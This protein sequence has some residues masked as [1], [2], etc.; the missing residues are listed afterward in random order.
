MRLVDFFCSFSDSVR[1]KSG[2]FII[3]IIVSEKRSYG[4][5]QWRCKVAEAMKIDKRA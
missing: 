1:I 3:I 4:Q 2:H 5:N